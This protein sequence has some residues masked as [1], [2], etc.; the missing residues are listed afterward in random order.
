[1]YFDLEIIKTV[2]EKLQVPH[3]FERRARKVKHSNLNG[4]QPLAAMEKSS[5]YVCGWFVGVLN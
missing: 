5:E 3:A 2:M 4:I 1:M